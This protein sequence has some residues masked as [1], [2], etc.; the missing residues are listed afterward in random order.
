[1]ELWRMCAFFG[2][3]R[4]GVTPKSV[5]EA[6]VIVLRGTMQCQRPHQGQLLKSKNVNPYTTSQ[7]PNILSSFIS[8]TVCLSSQFGFVIV[9]VNMVQARFLKL[10]EKWSPVQLGFS[11]SNASQPTRVGPHCP[12]AQTSQGFGL[13]KPLFRIHRT[14]EKRKSHFTQ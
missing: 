7:N 13:M 10:H 8:V 11:K 14:V 1:M 2:R 5:Q 4:I 9:T 3:G 12:L 6:F